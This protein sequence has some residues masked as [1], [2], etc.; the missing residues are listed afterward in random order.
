MA[1]EWANIE[2]DPFVK[3]AEI[4]EELQRLDGDCDMKGDKEDDDD[5]EAEDDHDGKADPNDP[6]DIDVNLVKETKSKLTL[7]EMENMLRVLREH[8]TSEGAPSENENILLQFGNNMMRAFNASKV[9][10]QPTIN[11][12][13]KLK[14]TK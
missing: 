11:T 2:D 14:Q 1:E 6:M 10:S 7:N 9:R 12:F 8:V 4:D 5:G 13:F 3:D